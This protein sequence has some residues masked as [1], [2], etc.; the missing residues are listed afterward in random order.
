[1]AFVPAVGFVIV[2]SFELFFDPLL[3]RPSYCQIN[4]RLMEFFSLQHPTGFDLFQNIWTL[5]S[6]T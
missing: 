5:S 1:M 3:P 4:C 2:V 6:Q